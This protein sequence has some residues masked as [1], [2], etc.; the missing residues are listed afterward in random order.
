MEL[1][2]GGPTAEIALLTPENSGSKDEY[3]Y[4]LDS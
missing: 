3:K 1:P 2:S 4:S